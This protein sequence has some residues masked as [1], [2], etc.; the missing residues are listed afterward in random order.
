M[1]D[2]AVVAWLEENAGI[3]L[4]PDAGRPVAGGC[5]NEGRLAESVDGEPVFLKFNRPDGLPLF[6]AERSGLELIAES[7]AIRV[8]RPYATGVVEGRAVLAMEGLPLTSRG[9]AASE[10]LMGE[11]VAALHGTPSPE[12]RFGAAFDNFIGST[13][14]PNGWMD[15]WADFYADRRLGHQ[16]RLAE[17]RDRRF[18]DGEAVVERVREHLS[19]LSIEPVLLHGDLWGGN[20]AFLDDGAPVLFDP[21]CY[22]GDR[23]ADVAFTRM[24]GGFG[25]GFYEGYRSAFPEPEPI[26]ETIYNLYHLLN[27]FN[28]FG[29]TYGN[30]AESAMRRILHELR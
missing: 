6:E 9:D 22:F 7:D 18:P 8:P 21:A 17:R 14:Q 4:R 19:G 15:S 20:A 2:P 26:R 10:R 5:I 27:H 1:I 30:Q 16:I 23:E 24:F 12:G 11:R 3:A 28:L 29:G 25:P 13:P